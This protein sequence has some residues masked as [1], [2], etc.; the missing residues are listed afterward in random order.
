MVEKSLNE[1][2]ERKQKMSKHRWGLM[3]YWKKIQHSSNRGKS[4]MSK[5][6]NEEEGIKE[7][8]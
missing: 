5:R 3:K 1:E 2:T 8:K 4:K 7:I 6:F